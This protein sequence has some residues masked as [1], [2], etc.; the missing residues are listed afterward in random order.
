MYIII[1][2]QAGSGAAAVVP[3]QTFADRN[4]A[5]SAMHQALSFAAVSSIEK[6]SV[7]MLDDE[8]HMLETR[9]YYH[10]PEQSS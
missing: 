5:E 7:L 4:A 3:P 8:G 6:H 1:E 2:I 10:E 9:C